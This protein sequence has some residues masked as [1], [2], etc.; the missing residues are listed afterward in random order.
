MA[1][2]L[3]YRVARGEVAGLFDRHVEA[4]PVGVN[5]A[6]DDAVVTEPDTELKAW[7]PRLRYSQQHRAD[8]R[9]IPDMDLLF[10]D[11]AYR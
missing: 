1:F 11:S 7:I 9:Q 3:P 5:E 2:D 4:R 10:V 8:L 6:I